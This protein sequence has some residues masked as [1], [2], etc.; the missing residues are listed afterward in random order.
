MIS[1][2]VIESKSTRTVCEMQR[3]G[4]QFGDTPF[5][6]WVVTFCLL[7]AENKDVTF[8]LLVYNV[9]S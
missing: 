4:F 3:D 9:H 8:L 2:A 7:I 6:A 5:I 1:S